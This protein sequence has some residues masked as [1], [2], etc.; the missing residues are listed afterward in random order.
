M[1]ATS[2]YW[3]HF[4]HEADIGVRGYGN[5]PAEAFEQ[6]ALAMTAVICDPDKIVAEQTITIEC[7]GTDLELLLIDWLNALIYEMATRRMLFGQ[8]KVEITDT[9]LSA[10]AAGEEINVVKHQPTVEIKGATFTLLKV[11][12]DSSGQWVAQTIVD[13]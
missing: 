5:T 13:V 10:S 2:P 3:E 7:R 8:F 12:Q 6:T 4:D 1:T 9:G 11:G